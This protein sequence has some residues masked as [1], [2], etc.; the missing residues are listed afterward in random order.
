MD[1]FPLERSNRTGPQFR[2]L[3]NRAN[4]DAIESE[5]RCEAP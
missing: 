5:P 1:L 3:A 2:E 4:L